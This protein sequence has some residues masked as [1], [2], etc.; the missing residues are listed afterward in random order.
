M[1]ERLRNEGREMPYVLCQVGVNCVYDGHH[2]AS[3]LHLLEVVRKEFVQ[4]RELQGP[5]AVDVVFEHAALHQL[6]CIGDRL[7]IYG[8]SEECRVIAVLFP[9]VHE[10]QKL[11]EVEGSIACTKRT[12][13]EPVASRTVHARQSRLWELQS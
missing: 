10:A 11:G 1:H 7:R 3:V 9:K 8:I 12:M 2:S 6:E 4:L 5:T 13:S